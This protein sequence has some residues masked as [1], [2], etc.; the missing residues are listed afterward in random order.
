MRYIE[1]MKPFLALGSFERK[2]LCGGFNSFRIRKGDE[3]SRPL[4]RPADA[5]TEG[6]L[7]C[8]LPG[9]PLL[10]LFRKT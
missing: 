4:Q 7:A 6:K 5:T 8:K 1:A 3:G 2:C 10:E 9:K